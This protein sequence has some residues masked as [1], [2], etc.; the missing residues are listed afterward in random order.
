MTIKSTFVALTAVLSFIVITSHGQNTALAFNGSNTYVSTAAGAYIVPVTGDLTVEFWAYVPV[1]GSGLREFISQGSSIAGQNFYVGTDFSSGNIRV[2]DPWQNSGVPMPVNQWTHIA[3]VRSGT[4]VSLYLNGVFRNSITGYTISTGGTSFKIG[5]Q[6]GANSEFTNG[7]VDEIR[8]WNVARTG[9]QIK[10]GL[11]GVSATSTGLVAYYQM[12]EGSGTSLLNATATTGLTGTLVNS[13]A[14][15]ASP[16]QFASNALQFD[17]VNDQVNIPV[18][19]IYNLTSGTIECWVNPGTLAGNA[20]ILGLRN[21]SGTRYSFHMSTT[22]LGLWTTASSLFKTVPFVSTTGIWYQL[23]F[24]SSA[25]MDTTGVFVNG[26]YIG[27]ITQGYNTAITGLPLTIGISKN[28]TDAEPFS[29]SIDEVRIWNT[30]R[31]QAQIQA[32]MNVTL[33]GSETGLVGLFSFDEGNAAGVNTNFVA[34][35]DGTSNNNHGTLANFALSGSTSNFVSHSLP[36]L[37]VTFTRYEVQKQGNT[38][39]IQWATAQEQNSRDFTVE[40]STDGSLYADIGT[41]AAAGNSN[42][43]QTYSYTDN[44]PLAGN[45]YYRLKQSDLDGQFIFTVVK[46][47]NFAE[48]SKLVWYLSGNRVATVHLSNGGNE[49]YSLVDMNGRVLQ[50]GRLS[51]GAV[52]LSQLTSGLYTVRVWTSSGTLQCKMSIP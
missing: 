36:L 42:V 29:G 37:P 48:G 51:A 1:I 20:C 45:N 44:S 11:L 9:A 28:A 5:N 46:L 23:A 10:Q 27:Q 41:V 25:A 39:L 19:S 52:T 32:N 16:I 4:T 24:V 14:W 38:A 26:N 17:G 18:N 50:K 22:Q 49:Y 2:G 12:N 7:T 21:A 35:L 3:V 33:S 43:P 8:V 31:T 47:L 40:R 13:P 6:F 15:V 34:A 30:M